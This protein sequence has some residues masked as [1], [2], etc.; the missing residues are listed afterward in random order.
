M[1]EDPRGALKL[2]GPSGASRDGSPL[3]FGTGDF[4]WTEGIG[5]IGT[6]EPKQTTW[7][8]FDARRDRTLCRLEPS[9]NKDIEQDLV[10]IQ[11]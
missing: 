6:R 5:D 11:Q 2:G 3:P 8:R 10:A 7:K 4:G 1:L 9:R